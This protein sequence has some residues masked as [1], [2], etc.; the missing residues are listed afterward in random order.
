[1]NPLQ[2]IRFVVLRELRKNLRSIKGIVLT[3]LSLLGGPLVAYFVV[4]K[5][6]H[7]L[8]G[9]ALADLQAQQEE[10]Y[11][12]AF[13][14]AVT[15]HYLSTM[16][17]ALVI[18]FILSIW[19]APLLIALSSFDAVSGEVQHRTVRF[20]TVRTRRSSYFVGKFLGAWATIALITFAMHALMWI[21]AIGQGEGAGAVL[22]WGLR[23]WL[24][25]LPISAVWC[26]IATFVASLVRTPV[27][28][29]LLTLGAFFVIW[30]F[31]LVIARG[32]EVSWLSYV[33]PN[34]YDILLLSPR[35]EK[36][37][38]A[39]GVCLGA[40]AA[41]IAVGAVLFQRRDI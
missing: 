14:D 10:V 9:V 2:E 38:T 25:S 32:A 22:S 4:K 41:L 1:M 21:V 28:S 29:L 35:I 24:V 39:F 36:V 23:F 27:L 3:A 34:S 18:M 8:A 15:G 12:K 16:P 40:S 37:G 7:E 31:G 11:T 6:H 26:A 19:L 20:W 5:I 13:N 33:Y 30:F 17:P